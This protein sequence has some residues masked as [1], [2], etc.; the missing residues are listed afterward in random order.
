MDLAR[1]L[2]GELVEVEARLLHRFG[3]YCWFIDVA[4]ASG[5]LG[6]LDLTVAVRM[7]WHEGFQMYGQNGSVLAKIYNP[8]LFKSSEVD[9]FHES[10]GATTRVLG[11]DGHF[12]RRQ[13]EAFADTILNGTAITGADIDDGLAS[14]RALVAIVQSVKTGRPVKLAEVAGAA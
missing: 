5:A 4:Y 13:L 11:P 3:A 7:D 8:W 14:I 2:G 12:Y 9:I 1:W 6:H 10:T